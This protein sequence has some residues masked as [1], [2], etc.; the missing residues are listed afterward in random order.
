MDQLRDTGAVGNVAQHKCVLM[1]QTGRSGLGRPQRLLVNTIM[2]ILDFIRGEIISDRLNDYRLLKIS[3][4]CEVSRR[5]IS[6]KK[7]DKSIKESLIF[8]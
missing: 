4:M 3:V 5:L 7:T 2:K 8:S 6:E 1:G